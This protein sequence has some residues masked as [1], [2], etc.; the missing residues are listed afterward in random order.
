MLGYWKS[1]LVDGVRLCVLSGHIPFA[2]ALDYISA[3][4]AAAKRQKAKR[5]RRNSKAR[6]Q[7]RQSA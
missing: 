1:R 3:S 5:Q 2:E 4:V 7:S 6:S